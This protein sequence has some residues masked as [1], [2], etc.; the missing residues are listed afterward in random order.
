[1]RLAAAPVDRQFSLAPRSCVLSYVPKTDKL[2][3]VAQASGDL[4][5]M[6]DELSD[7]KVMFAFIRFKVSEGYKFVYVAWCGEG[8]S[9]MMR[10]NFA[11]HATDMEN[12]LTQ[13]RLGFH[14][15]INARSENDLQE[16]DIIKKINSAK[17][18][19][20][21]KAATKKEGLGPDIKDVSAGFWYFFLI[22]VL[23]HAHHIL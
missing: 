8:V 9:G 10:G 15:R 19:N 22:F 20:F 3:V 12:F 18:A 16:E 7:G 2:K 23:R 13:N 17:G 6:C 5:D 11:N 1:M 4:L 14:V 21:I